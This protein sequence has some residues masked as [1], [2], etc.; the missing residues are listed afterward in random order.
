M[1]S[2][3]CVSLGAGC[4]DTPRRGLA[5]FV[6]LH[7]L[8]LNCCL[9]CCPLCLSLLRLGAGCCDAPRRGLAGFVSRHHLNLTCCLCSV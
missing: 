3:L 4:C 2:P 1:L 9:R 5:G 8:N 6:P 7:D